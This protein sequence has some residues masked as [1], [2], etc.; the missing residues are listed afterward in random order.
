MVHFPGFFMIAK[1]IVLPL[2]QTLYWYIGF[3]IQPVK[4]QLS[5]AAQMF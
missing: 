5:W 1:K 4:T 2:V 3:A